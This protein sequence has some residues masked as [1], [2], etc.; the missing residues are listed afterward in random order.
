V[1]SAGAIHSDMRRLHKAEVVRWN[2]SA[3]GRKSGGA[4]RSAG[5]VGGKEYIVQ[6]GDV[7]LFSAFWI[8][9]RDKEG[10]DVWKKEKK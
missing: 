10:N 8:K 5:A 4:R 3:G 9:K 2:E 1:A 7:I 6:E